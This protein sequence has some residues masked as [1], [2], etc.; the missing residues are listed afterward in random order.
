M[1]YKAWFV[2]FNACAFSIKLQCLFIFLLLFFF[3]NY[4]LIDMRDCELGRMGDTWVSSLEFR[5]G[6]GVLTVGLAG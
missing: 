5:G 3:H 1:K 4:L 2:R 6:R